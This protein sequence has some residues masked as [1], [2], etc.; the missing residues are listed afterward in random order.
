MKSLK[1]LKQLCFFVLLC[2][3]IFVVGGCG[4]SSNRIVSQNPNTQEI[5]DE[6]NEDDELDVGI[7]G[8][9]PAKTNDD[10]DVLRVLDKVLATDE[11]GVPIIFDYAPLPESNDNTDDSDGTAIN[12]LKYV[13][14][15]DLN[16][17][18]EFVQIFG[19]EKNNEYIIKYSHSGRNLNGSYLKFRITAPEDQIMILDLLGN[20]KTSNDEEL[21]NAGVISKS[22]YV[23][24]NYEVIPEES[25]CIMIYSFKAPLTGDYEIAIKEANPFNLISID[26]DETK[27]YE[28][29]FEFR[30]YTAGETYSAADDEDKDGKKLSARKILALQR[31]ALNNATEF[32]ENGLPIA[33]ES[34]FESNEEYGS[35]EESTTNNYLDSAY[36]V[37]DEVYGASNSDSEKIIIAPRIDNIPYDSSF[38]PGAGFY[39]HSG[40]RAIQL[41]ALYDDIF[42]DNAVDSFTIERPQGDYSM[43]SS[44]NIDYVSTEDEFLRLTELDNLNDFTLLKDALDDKKHKLARLGLAGSKTLYLRYEYYESEPRMPE[45][46]DLKLRRAV[47][48]QLEYDFDTFQ[49]EYGDYFVAGYKFGLYYEALIEI[50]AEPYNCRFVDLKGKVYYDAEAI[51]NYIGTYIKNAFNDPNNTSD[52]LTKL[53]NSLKNVMNAW[54]VSVSIPNITHSGVMGEKVSSLSELAKNLSDFKKTAEQTPS[55]QFERLYATLIRYREIEKVKDIIPEELPITAEHYRMIRELNKIIYL[56]RCYKSA[57]DSIPAAHLNN[58]EARRIEWNNE[59]LNVFNLYNNQLNRLCSD[60]NFVR[61]YYNKFSQLLEKYKGL[62]HRYVFYR[63]FLA[64]QQ[65]VSNGVGNW[66]DSD[67]SWSYPHF[68]VGFSENDVA[69]NKFVK[70]DLSKWRQ[71]GGQ[72]LY[73]AVEAWYE[74]PDDA[75]NLSSTFPDDIRPFYYEGGPI[76]T[77]GS[78]GT[79][80]RGHTFGKKSYHW[81]FERSAWGILRRIE[82]KVDFKL[83]DMPVSKYPFVGLVD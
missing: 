78:S 66:T 13:S 59:F 81:K 70:E 57:V 46:S 62:N 3:L 77:N 54:H 32:D 11:N 42:S 31:L 55:S 51:A 52:L 10:P 68:K 7:S 45:M 6:S 20:G 67:D 65:N 39:A 30:F 79:D 25:P 34:N 9:V 33:F 14:S 35:N 71:Y 23:E 41:T 27:N 15:K 44:F 26:I 63:Y 28:F 58:G 53:D 56:T 61:E 4:G 5:S 73:V 21:E 19:L 74:F 49:R 18:G 8:D 50:K 76:N 72:G 37:L 64:Y 69:T 40:L 80:L 36:G 38:A 16:E 43:E 60:I 1:L 22:I 24:T 83:I 12:F 82:Y 47:V 29:P 2:L 48:K 75:A 17:N